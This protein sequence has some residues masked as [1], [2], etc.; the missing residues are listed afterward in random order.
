MFGAFGRV[1]KPDHIVVE[2]GEVIFTADK[3]E[4]KEAVKYFHSLYKEGLIDPESF[5]QAVTDFNA[6]GQAKDYVLGSFVNYNDHGVVGAERAKDYDYIFPP[7]KGPDNQQIWGA[8]EPAY[9]VKGA[10]AI[11]KANPYPEITARWID[12]VYESNMSIEFAFGPF[13]LTQILHDDGKVERVPEPEGMTAYEWRSLE[14]PNNFFVYVM[15]N[16]DRNRTIFNETEIAREQL[17]ADAK[18]YLEK[19]YFPSVL[20]S[21]ED[22][23]KLASLKTDIMEFV[24][25][26]TAEWIIEGNIDQDWDSYVSQ[27]KR[28]G[29][30]ELI[31][32]HQATYDRFK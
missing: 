8:Y 27:L 9:F 17:F 29:L 16:E 10:F 18:P 25:Q 19:E 32:I 12:Q 13:G 2:N 20:F 1:D 28:M 6:K 26:K 22:E 11:T 24:D 5:T 15:L 14:A 4:Y 3:E 23:Q 31:N 30:D 21:Q 7:L